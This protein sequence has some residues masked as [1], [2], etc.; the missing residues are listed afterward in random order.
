MCRYLCELNGEFMGRREDSQQH[1]RRSELR[2][3]NEEKPPSYSWVSGFSG[4]SSRRYCLQVHEGGGRRW[5]T[6]STL[7]II[8]YR[9]EEIGGAVEKV[10]RRKNRKKK[11][12]KN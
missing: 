1:G 10:F 9:S 5:F 4:L 2:W 11:R 6:I 8:D 12:E 7:S 3:G